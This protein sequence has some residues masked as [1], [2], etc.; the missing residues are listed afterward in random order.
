MLYIYICEADRSPVSLLATKNKV[1]Q[2]NKGIHKTLG[3]DEHVYNLDCGDGLRGVCKS[4]FIKLCT[5]NMCSV[6]CIY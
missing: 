6:S 2:N 5:L 3:G 1:D 4:K